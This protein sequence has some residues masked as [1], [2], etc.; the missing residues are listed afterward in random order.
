MGRKKH[1][2]EHENHERWLVSYADFITLLF[3]FFVVM[4]SV[5]RVDNKK[6][7]QTTEAIRWA[8]HMSGSGGGGGGQPSVFRGT[9]G[10]GD[11]AS[12]IVGLGASPSGANASAGTQAAQ[13]KAIEMLRKKLEKKLRPFLL[14]KSKNLSVQVDVDARHLTIRLAAQRFFEPGQSALAP[15]ALPVLDAVADEL[16]ALGKPV[17]VEG[18]TDETAISGQRWQSNWELSA[19]RAAT[20]TNFLE[21][22]HKFDPHLLS[23]VGFGSTRPLPGPDTP[24]QRELNRRIA[25]VV[26]VNSTEPLGLAAP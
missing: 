13:Q 12:D 26:E 2:E 15:D 16:K 23:A 5:S 20:V 10:G 6:L 21:K 11:C 22:A 8:M 17:R 24:E 1:H 7:A 18:H 25:F 14:D 9:S 19:A 4:Y 3:A